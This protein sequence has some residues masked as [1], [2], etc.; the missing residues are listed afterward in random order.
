MR[1]IFVH[2]EVVAIREE[3]VGIEALAEEAG[4]AAFADDVGFLQRARQH[5]EGQHRLG[6]AASGG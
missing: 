5:D 2:V 3:R 6:R 4:G 1:F